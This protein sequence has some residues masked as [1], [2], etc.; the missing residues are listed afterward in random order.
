[1]SPGIVSDFVTFS[2]TNLSFNSGFLA[3]HVKDVLKKLVN[4]ESKDDVYK[5]VALLWSVRRFLKPQDV[6]EN[7]NKV[8][9]KSTSLQDDMEQGRTLLLLTL[10]EGDNETRK[11][12]EQQTRR[13]AKKSTKVFKALVPA[14]RKGFR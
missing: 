14:K 6:K 1:M 13:L 10:I 5:A 4:S 7:I 11:R 12:I 3:N 8:L 9:E 2:L